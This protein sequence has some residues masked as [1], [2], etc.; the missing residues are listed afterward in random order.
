MKTPSTPHWPWETRD[1]GDQAAA[2]KDN[3]F[4]LDGG[5]IHTYRRMIHHMDEGIGRVMDT[6]ERCGVADMP[7]R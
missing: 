2:V 1:D 5:S 4:H 7:A 3:L 6:L